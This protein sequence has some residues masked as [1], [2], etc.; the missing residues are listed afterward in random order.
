MYKCTSLACTIVYEFTTAELG[1]TP[2][3][4]VVFSFWGKEREEKFFNG[5]IKE[6]KNIAKVL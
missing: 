6:R 2:R 5:K 4:Y 1:Y 3:V